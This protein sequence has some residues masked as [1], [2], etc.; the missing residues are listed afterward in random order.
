MERQKSDVCAKFQ[1]LNK[2]VITPPWTSSFNNCKNI[3]VTPA[4]HFIFCKWVDI[5]TLHS[6]RSS[7]NHGWPKLTVYD[8]LTKILDTFGD[9]LTWQNLN[10]WGLQSPASAVILYV[11]QQP[12]IQILYK[13][14]FSCTYILIYIFFKNMINFL[15]ISIF[16]Y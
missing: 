9:C 12:G 6:R 5:N 11:T 1:F 7:Y 16:S 13:Y 10:N 8:R 15:H 3:E 14:L 4:T 2:Y